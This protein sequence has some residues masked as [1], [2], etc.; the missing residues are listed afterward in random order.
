MRLPSRRNIVN[1]LGS[2]IGWFACILGAA[3]GSWW[4]GPAV[5]SVYLIIHFLLLEKRQYRGEFLFLG[6]SSV[7]GVVVD[8]LKKTTGLI[9]YSADSSIA[10]LAPVWIVAMWT[11]FAST[12]G[13]SMAWIQGRVLI[14]A[15]LGGVFGPASY[16]AG[17]RFGAVKFG[18]SLMVTVAVLSLVWASVMALL[19]WLSARLLVKEEHG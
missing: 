14:A 18:A 6:I 9:V 2:Q 7:L 8:S 16:V 10:Y 19:A 11:L 13:A 4:F 15:L 3:H 1:G 5:V 17:M 12:F